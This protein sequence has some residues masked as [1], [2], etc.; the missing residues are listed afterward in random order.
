[1]TMEQYGFTDQVKKYFRYL[2]EDFGFSIVVEEKSNR[3]AFGNSLIQFRSNAVSVT[4]T[5][6]RG[7]VLIDIGP[8]PEVPDYQFSLVSVMEFLAP[9]LD[10]PVPSR[11]SL[12]YRVRR[13]SEP[14]IWAGPR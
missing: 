12:R 13:T 4:V 8:Y 7:Q 1:M 11:G 3:Q 6:D 9:D 2:T 14:S 5:L 10:E